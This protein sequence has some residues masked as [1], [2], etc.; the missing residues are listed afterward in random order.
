MWLLIFVILLVILFIPHKDMYCGV[1]TTNPPQSTPACSLP[2]ST[3]CSYNFND[4]S[5]CHS[6]CDNLANSLS[7]TN[8]NECSSTIQ[9]FKSMCHKTCQ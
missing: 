3:W 2:D 6:C 7:S 5:S 9:N 1:N 4:S 8:A